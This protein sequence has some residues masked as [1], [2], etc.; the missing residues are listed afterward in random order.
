MLQA[1]EIVAE[2]RCRVF[3]TPAFYS[4]VPCSNLFPETGYRNWGFTGFSQS[5]QLNAGILPEIIL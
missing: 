4:E 5:L 1:D 2:I 3:R